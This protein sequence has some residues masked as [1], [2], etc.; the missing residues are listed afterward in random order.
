MLLRWYQ[1]NVGTYRFYFG[2]HHHPRYNHNIR[3]YCYYYCT[4]ESDHP[5]DLPQLSVA[6][7][8]RYQPLDIAVTI[9]VFFDSMKIDNRYEVHHQSHRLAITILPPCSD[10]HGRH[11]T[12]EFGLVVPHEDILD[13]LVPFDEPIQCFPS[14]KP[15]TD[16]L[17]PILHC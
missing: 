13:F 1:T 10:H 14:Y 7:L 3:Y 2:F 11:N 9:V 6:T 17:S 16:R 15:S 12:A 4:S 8:V 5:S